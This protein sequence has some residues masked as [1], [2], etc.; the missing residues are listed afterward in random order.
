[1]LET[2]LAAKNMSPIPSFSSLPFLY[3]IEYHGNLGMGVRRI[4]RSS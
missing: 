1:M 2:W 3:C 4:V